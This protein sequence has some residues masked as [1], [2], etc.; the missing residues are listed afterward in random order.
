MR[1]VTRQ[2][3]SGRRAVSSGDTKNSRIARVQST[4]S[5][6]DVIQTRGFA[7][8][9]TLVAALIIAITVSG[10]IFI[11]AQLSR[12]GVEARARSGALNAG[13]SALEAAR[14]ENTDSGVLDAHATQQTRLA[15]ASVAGLV[16]VSGRLEATAQWSFFGQ[17]ESS[18]VVNTL[19]YESDTVMNIVSRDDSDE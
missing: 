5:C 10:S 1:R 4:E 11:A 19:A 16:V 13:F 15:S 18:V 2:N 14:F 8:V 7:L 9:E 6:T 12:S 3:S 17:N